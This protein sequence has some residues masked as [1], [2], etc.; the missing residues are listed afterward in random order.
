MSLYFTK[1]SKQIADDLTQEL[2]VFLDSKIDSFKDEGDRIQKRLFH[3]LDV[4]DT[5]KSRDNSYVKLDKKKDSWIYKFGIDLTVVPYAVFWF[6]G[7]GTNEKIGP[8]RVYEL[9]VTR[10]LDFVKKSF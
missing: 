2:E 10:F 6:Q 1:S 4:I 8:R 7:W 5:G 3:E 9:S